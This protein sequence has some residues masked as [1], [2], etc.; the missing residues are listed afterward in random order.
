MTKPRLYF[1]QDDGKT[2]TEC[3]QGLRVL[4]EDADMP[5]DND[6]PADLSFNFTEEGLISDVLNGRKTEVLGTDSEMY[7]EVIDR[8]MEHD[9]RY[10]ADGP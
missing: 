1:S 4:V 3:P 2:W 10:S 7:G 6:T 9:S 5:G 8:L